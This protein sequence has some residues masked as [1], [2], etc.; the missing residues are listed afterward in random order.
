MTINDFMA[1]N[2]DD[3]ANALWEGALLGGRNDGIFK[4]LLYQIDAF[5]VEV[6]FNKEL[7]VI[8]RFKPFKSI[9]LLEP[10]LS[11]INIQNVLQ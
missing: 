11:K 4:V 3:Q 2:E 9:A 8:D 7:Q 1:M 6:Y 10:Y 5:Y